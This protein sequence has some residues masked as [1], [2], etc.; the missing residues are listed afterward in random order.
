MKNKLQRIKIFY[1]VYLVLIIIT[2]LIVVKFVI[3]FYKLSIETIVAENNKYLDDENKFIV[4][5]RVQLENDGKF[6]YIES[7]NGFLKEDGY[8]FNDIKMHGYFGDVKA[9]QLE[10]KDDKNILEFTIEPNF[11]IYLNNIE[12]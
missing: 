4:R 5:P 3:D 8:L 6:E 9:G 12:K 10:I 1:I 2:S 11:T 7:K